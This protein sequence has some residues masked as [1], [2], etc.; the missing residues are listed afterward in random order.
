MASEV[1]LM[2]RDGNWKIVVE[3]GTNTFL[4]YSSIGA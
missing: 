4:F 2:S 1:T 3:A